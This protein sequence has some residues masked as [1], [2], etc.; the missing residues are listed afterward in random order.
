MDADTLHVAKTWADV[1]FVVWRD[2]RGEVIFGLVGLLTGWLGL[3]KPRY[4]GKFTRAGDR[5]GGRGK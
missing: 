4:R 2:I 5:L 1:A 3:P